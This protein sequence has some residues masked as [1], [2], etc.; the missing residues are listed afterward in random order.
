MSENYFFLNAKKLQPSQLYISSNKK[1]KNQEWLK[2]RDSDYDA[3]PIIEM[4]EKLLMTDGH[5]RAVILC[6]LGVEDIKVYWDQDEIDLEAYKQCLLWCEK[7]NISSPFDLISRV[8]S[9]EAFEEKWIGRCQ[10]M[11]Q[12]L[13]ESKLTHTGI[14][15]M[16]YTR[17]TCHAFYKCYVPD[18]MMTEDVYVYDEVWVNRYYD[19]KV[20]DPLRCFFA[21]E[22]EGRVIGE[23]QLKKLDFRAGHGTLSIILANDS[24]KNKGF[25]TRAELLMIEY[26]KSQLKLKTIFADTIHRN[27]RSRHVLE[28]IGFQ[29]IKR[30]NQLDYFKIDL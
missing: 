12:M 16:P 8:I 26:A 22:N 29:F 3:I 15:L 27:T 10:R 23:I 1:K 4:E 28:K 5:T 6:E 7:E 19:L 30:D 2:S 21:I 18:P 24:V 14:S 25:G 9:Q 17:E 11:H 20:K 13:E